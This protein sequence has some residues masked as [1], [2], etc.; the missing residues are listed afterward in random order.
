[1]TYTMGFGCSRGGSYA[2]IDKASK[3][4]VA[5]AITCPPRNVPFSK[6]ASEM[7]KFLNKAGMEMGPDVLLN[8][9]MRSLGTWMA[10]TEGFLGSYLNDNFLYI[11]CFAT[12]PEYQGK[13][14]GTALLKFL[15]KVADADGVVSYLETAGLRNVGFYTYKG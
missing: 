5:A 14:C 15:G 4:V 9:R 6:S 10:N 3:K 12:D 11:S 7:T 2:L 8:P 13:G 1:M